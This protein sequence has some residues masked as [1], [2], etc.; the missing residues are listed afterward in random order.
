MVGTMATSL[1]RSLSPPT[2]ATL[3]DNMFLNLQFGVFARTSLP[4]EGV[5]QRAESQENG[6]SL[7]CCHQTPM[8]LSF[9]FI[10]PPPLSL[11]FPC[12]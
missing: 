8:C 11:Q 4:L 6:V 9:L 10:P 3:G 7:Q 12:L 1:E 5:A 2:E